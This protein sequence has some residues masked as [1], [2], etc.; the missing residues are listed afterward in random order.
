MNFLS[1]FEAE[2]LKLNVYFLDRFEELN[3]TSNNCLHMLFLS[4][5]PKPTLLFKSLIKFIYLTENTLKIVF[6]TL[7]ELFPLPIRKCFKAK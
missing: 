4:F 5:F 2:L 3:Q 7:I 1:S 6:Y